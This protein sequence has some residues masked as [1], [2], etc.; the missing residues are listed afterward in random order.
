MNKLRFLGSGIY[1][2]IMSILCL[3]AYQKVSNTG[4]CKVRNRIFPSEDS[5]QHERPPSLSFASAEL[6][7]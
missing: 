7:H 1:I 6:D 2:V 4:W 5:D 3:C